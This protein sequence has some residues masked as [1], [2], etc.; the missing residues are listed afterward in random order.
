MAA[1]KILTLLA[2]LPSLAWSMTPEELAT[3]IDEGQAPTV[4]D[5]RHKPL[6]EVERIPGSVH[7]ST[8]SLATR[9]LPPLGPVVVVGDGIDVATTK[10]AV[11][12]LNRHEG[13]RAEILDGGFPG[14][15]SLHRMSDSTRSEMTTASLYR[16]VSFKQLKHA[17]RV[18]GHEV[19]IVDLRTIEAPTRLDD[20]DIRGV[21]VVR[22]PADA[23]DAAVLRRILSERERLK[24]KGLILVDDGNDRAIRIAQKLKVAGLT[25]VGVLVGGEKALRGGGEES[26]VTIQHGVTP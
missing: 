12:A 8:T 19:V 16:Q 21:T 23:E 14:W 25:R 2:L 13:I 18:E 4:M 3:L 7:L 1:M 26:T 17:V 20:V 10:A 24:G 5:I 11:E 22:A 9:T 15:T 6:F